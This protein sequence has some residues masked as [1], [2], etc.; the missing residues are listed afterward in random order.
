VIS[1]WNTFLY[2]GLDIA[3]SRDW[4]FSVLNEIKLYFKL[5]KY[6][7]MLLSFANLFLYHLYLLMYIILMILT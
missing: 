7:F 2:L 6:C 1:E 3:G 5:L 4:L